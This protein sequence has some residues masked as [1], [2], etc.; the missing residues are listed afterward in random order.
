M[1]IDRS[2]A[3][4]S[5]YNSLPQESSRPFDCD[6]DGFVYGMIPAPLYFVIFPLYLCY[7]SFISNFDLIVLYL[8]HQI[9]RIGEG[10]GVMVLEVSLS[11]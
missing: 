1:L 6:R 9:Y 7:F 8:T 2:R 3:L 10:C 4:A 5:K 11:P